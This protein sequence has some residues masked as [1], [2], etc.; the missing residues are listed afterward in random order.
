MDKFLTGVGFIKKLILA[1]GLTRKIS[2]VFILLIGGFTALMIFVPETPESKM[3]RKLEGMVPMTNEEKA[4]VSQKLNELSRDTDEDGLKDWEEIIYRTDPQNSDTDGDETNDGDEIK[5]GRN[6][7]AKGP[8]D[9]NPEPRTDSLGSE[10]DPEEIISKNFTLS[11][12]RDMS[13]TVTPYLTED[14][15]GLDNLN[16]ETI[17]P[18]IDRVRALGTE[19]GFGEAGAI[20]K[21]DLL[22][23]NNSGKEAVK[24]YFNSVYAVY[25][26]TFN[27][28]KKNDLEILNA[29][30]QEQD[31]SRLDELNEVIGAFQNSFAGV[32]KIPV[33]R[34]YEDFAVRELNYLQQSKQIVESFK[35]AEL[36]PFLVVVA[37][38]KRI[39]LVEEIR[40]FHI[41]TGQILTQRG[42]VFRPN[43]G[44]Y[45]FFQ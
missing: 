20:K 40:K 18:I 39:K 19:T 1:K 16:E 35:K 11:F 2:A 21:S 10:E 37:A 17:K 6:P 22:I 15:G 34:G 32:K 29:A 41:E 14:S 9:K 4:L 23:S 36:D 27:T 3:Q 13:N 25:E 33:P 45:I 30:L 28:L 42:I 38:P 43:E 12:L 7:I 44:G 31:F 24:T 8:N 26:K 5:N